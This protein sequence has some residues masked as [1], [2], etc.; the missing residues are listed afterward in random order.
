M[1]DLWKKTSDKAIGILSGVL[2]LVTLGIVWL[3][4][5]GV[6]FMM[7]DIWYS[8]KLISNEASGIPITSFKDIIESQIW[9]YYNWGGR[10]ITHGLLQILLQLGEKVVD[11]LNVIAVIVLAYVMYMM[12][13]ISKSS[14]VSQVKRYGCIAW[15]TMGTF[16]AMAMMIGLNAN[17]KMS[18]FWQAGAVN[19]LYITTFILLFLYCF[20]RE[21]PDRRLY[22]ITLWIIPL[23]IIAGWSNENMGP[24]AWILSL[25]IILM[26]I[27]QKNKVYLWMILGNQLQIVNVAA[28]GGPVVNIHQSHIGGSIVSVVYT[29]GT[30]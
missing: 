21:N 3:V 8:E 28:Y 11:V 19:Y 17:W 16:C 10:S 9:H 4:N 12:A 7:D 2:V 14:E 13:S 27:Y 1:K 23:G 25:L 30:V 24:T 29:T 18:M 22:G 15:L 5:D 26:R 20:L 6:P